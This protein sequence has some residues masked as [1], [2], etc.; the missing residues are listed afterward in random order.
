MLLKQ[1]FRTHGEGYF[2]HQV[3][4]GVYGI[5]PIIKSNNSKQIENKALEATSLVKTP[6]VKNPKASKQGDFYG[7][8]LGAGAALILGIDINIKIGFNR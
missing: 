6:H 1:S 3:D 4:Y 5:L 2:D 8:D 7:V